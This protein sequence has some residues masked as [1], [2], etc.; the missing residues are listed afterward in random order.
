M[1][2]R[3]LGNYEI[4]DKLGEGG[5]GQ[6]WR[7]RDARLSRSVAVK[8]LP[9]DVAG[10]PGRRQR[11]EQEA[12]ALG[13][14]NHP[15]IVAVYDIGQSDGQ[16][17]IVSELV[18][19]ES[20]RAVIE[21]GPVPGRKLLDI[22]TQTAE[23]I[24]AAHALGIVHRDLK[25]ENI[26]LT[27]DGRVKVLD[28][29]LAKQNAMAVG[30]DAATIALSQPGLVLGTVGYMSPEQVR[31]H[32]VDARSD[33]FSFGCVLYEMAAG[34]Q[35]FEGKSSADVMSAVLKDEPPEI[36]AAT[37]VPPALDAILRRCLEKDPARRF[38]SAAD[39]A[40][41]LRS[42]SNLSTSQPAIAKAPAARRKWLLPVLAGAAAILLFAGGYFLRAR[43][44][45]VDPPRFERLTF[46]QGHVT[47][48]R[49]APDGQNVIY[50][51]DWD[52]EP[53]R[54]YFGTPGNPESRD[55]GAPPD[56]RLLAVSSKGDI[57]L[58]KG[59]FTPDGAGTLA[60]AT[61]AGGQ[62]RGLLENVRSA[63]WSPDGSQ[64]AVV[65]RI[66]GVT[67]LEYPV[68]NVLY[69]SVWIRSG[70]RVSPD[71]QHIALA[72]YANGSATQIH[73][74]DRAG[75]VRNLG[76]VSG[77]VT[78][79]GL[80]D[81][82]WSRDGSEIWY[83][84]FDEGAR[85][86]IMAINMSGKTRVVARFPSHVNLYDVATDGRVLLGTESGRLGIRGVAPGETTERDL[87]CLESSL[88]RG[89]T[90]DGRII[91]ADILGESGGPKGS[92]Y[93]RYTDG[94]PPVRLGDGYAFG[95]S[96]D[97][98]WVTGYDSRD[99]TERH[100]VLIP[101]GPGE[102]LS[103]EFV[104]M[105]KKFGVVLGWLGDENYLILGISSTGKWQY[106]QWN[107][108]SGVAKPASSDGMVDSNLFV[109]PDRQ[110]FVAKTSDDKWATCTV[111]TAQCRPIPGLSVHDWP[112]AFR[113][114][115]KAVYVIMHHDEN[116]MMMVELVDLATGA[117][118]PWKH[119]MPAI[120]VD[121][122]SNLQITPDGRAYA[123]NYSYARSDLYLTKGL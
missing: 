86:T 5:M 96:P 68:G 115:G 8:I 90:P 87:S 67:R 28:F 15:N 110:Q 45:P 24:A 83:R 103:L 4:L 18:E 27:R 32:V 44:A 11:F 60:S 19:G 62:S 23:A 114:D 10:D 41:A 13:A 71:G 89:I 49:F 47:A 14:L 37:P 104:H 81:L 97:G 102:P 40:F 51:A 39:L 116:K 52:D 109:A 3:K 53:G 25:P 1:T 94:S 119:I 80:V 20:L 78:E 112:V 17:Y 117:R 92:I 85:N 99:T 79:T 30:E 75:K 16:A 58:L 120:P 59:P 82:S 84:S 56:S 33:I 77:Q 63:D 29:G 93:W 26:M 100:Y 54:L 111:A 123:Y 34:R 106:F 6:V 31:G 66:D 70:I 46:R 42:I 118:T 108:P 101:T 74:V 2:G 107:K 73:L 113:Q 65:R 36:V 48:A 105:P 88:L 50:A 121:E 38:Q 95:I 22:A 43:L 55:L 72:G 76:I 57:L 9:A 7:A 64:M 122:L 35:A 98:K 61:V 12:R 21:R 91:L 69:K